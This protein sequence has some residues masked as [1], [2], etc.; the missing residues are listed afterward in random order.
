MSLQKGNIPYIESCL[1]HVRYGT[2]ERTV[3]RVFILLR[4]NWMHRNL[5]LV[6]ISI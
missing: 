1:G 3:L 6:E 2:L 4:Q 5:I